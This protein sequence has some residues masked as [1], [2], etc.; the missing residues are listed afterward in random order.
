MTTNTSLDRIRWL[1]SSAEGPTD[2]HLPRWLFLR[3]LGLIY[4]SAFVS[5]VFQI[6]GLI[7]PK[8]FFRRTNIWKRSRI[9][10]DISEVCGSLQHCSGSPPEPTC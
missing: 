5:L 8:E 4:F 10:S 7:G 6:R 3:A 1:F 2:R 9:R